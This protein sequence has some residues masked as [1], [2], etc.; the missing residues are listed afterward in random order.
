MT[1]DFKNYPPRFVPIPLQNLEEVYSFAYAL[2]THLLPER[3]VHTHFLHSLHDIATPGSLCEPEGPQR[4]GNECRTD[5]EREG[6]HSGAREKTRAQHLFSK[7]RGRR[8]D[9]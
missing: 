7:E 5:V 9:G 1:F 8:K 6:E 2:R 4:G 3:T